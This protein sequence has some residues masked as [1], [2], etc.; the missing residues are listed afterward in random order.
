MI[1]GNG[2]ELVS[3]RDWRI[4]VLEDKRGRLEE[5]LQDQF[6]NRNSYSHLEST[7]VPV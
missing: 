2:A 3:Q 7:M 6:D 5:E 4:D 1:V